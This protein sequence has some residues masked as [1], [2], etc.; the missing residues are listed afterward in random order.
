MNISANSITN[1]SGVLLL[2]GKATLISND[3]FVNKNGG[4]IKISDVQIASINGSVINETYSNTNN[5]KFGI[6]DFTYTNIGKT[7][8]IEATN[9]NLVIQANKDITNIGANLSAKDSLLLQ[10]QSGDINLNAIKLEQGY[11]VYFKGGFDKAKR[12]K[13]P[14]F[15][16]RSK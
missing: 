13:L 15:K 4:S 16:Y 10:T 3:D 9:G 8:S 5:L 14:N 1:N 7:S 2:K 6:N 12:C 11:N